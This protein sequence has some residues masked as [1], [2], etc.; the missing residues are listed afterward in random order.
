MGSSDCEVL[1]DLVKT[2]RASKTLNALIL[3][4]GILSVTISII[5]LII[6]LHPQVFFTGY[7]NGYISLTS[8]EL[9]YNT[10]GKLITLPN[11]DVVHIASLTMVIHSI[12]MLAATILGLSMMRSRP[13]T[14]A[15]MVFGSTLSLIVASGVLRYLLQAFEVDAGRIMNYANKGSFTFRTLAGLIEYPG[16][17]AEKTVA[18]ALAYTYSW[19]IGLTLHASV[20]ISATTV[21]LAT[22]KYGSNVVQVKNPSLLVKTL[23]RAQTLT[24]IVLIAALLYTGASVFAYNPS[25]L[26]VIPTPPPVVL[27]SSPHNYTCIL[28]RTS[29]TVITYTDFEEY[30]V[31]GWTS[32]G[33]VWELSTGGGFRGNALR[34]RD[35]NGG[36][37]RASQ[38][39]WN[40]R[41]DGYTSLWVSVRVR[42][43]GVDG[44][45]GIGL[46]SAD[47]T[48]LYEISVRSTATIY[49]YDGAWRLIGRTSV[50]GYDATRWYTL[51]LNYIVTTTAVNFSLWIYDDTGSL[52]ATLSASDRGGT[53]FTPAY[54]GVT[55]DTG[56]WFRFEDFIVSTLD[57]RTITFTGFY[58]GM[59]V[60]V[61]DNLGN[62]VNSTIAP[63]ASFTLGVTRD[64]VVG[65]GVDGRIVV[66]YPDGLPCFVYNVPPTDAILGGDTYRL[67]SYAINTALGANRTSAVISATIS[68]SSLATTSAIFVRAV[69]V[70]SKSYYARLILSSQ[71]ILDQLYAN[72]SLISPQSY[73]TT[74]ITIVNGVATSNLTSWIEI[75]PSSNINA[76]LSAYFPSTDRS[77]TL[78]ML[79]EYSTLPGGEGVCVYY[80]IELNLN[81]ASISSSSTTTYPTGLNTTEPNIDWTGDVLDINYVDEIPEEAGLSMR[82]P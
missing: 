22:W 60:E 76:V 68:A 47:R 52:V 10:N 56:T 39:Y 8:Y 12:F 50:P 64:I 46:L 1:R 26:S 53:R 49:K 48:R 74:N 54:A 58:S 28:N 75:K 19:L 73:T 42:A 61:W 14:S 72:I 9:R 41:I 59:G 79:L 40:T 30:P 66:K 77:A 63:A 4:S 82:E 7:I 15:S 62:L 20:I 37:G 35:N 18:N 44:Y 6:L 25:S 38:Y 27:D 70:D 21:I 5:Y 71:S 78:Y 57:P 17:T 33:G 36:V 24:S 67:T 65:T 13:L 55:I 45:K 69:N 34:G 2:Q 32:Y 80:P 23:L 3:A 51:V 81:A 43:E 11:M 29:R 31:S 16:I